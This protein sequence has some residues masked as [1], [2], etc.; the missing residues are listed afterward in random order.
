ML[1]SWLTG[2]A[3]TGRSYDLVAAAPFALGL[4]VMTIEFV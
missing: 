4:L 1:A 2:T 3:A